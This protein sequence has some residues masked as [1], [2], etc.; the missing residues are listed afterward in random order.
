MP[1]VDSKCFFKKLCFFLKFSE[2]L[3][4]SIDPFCFSIDRKL[5][6]NV[7]ESLC[8]FRSIEAVFRSIETRETCFLKGQNVFFKRCFFKKKFNLSSLSDLAKA[9]PKIFCRFPPE[10]LQGFCL[11]RPVSPFCPS[12]CVLFHDFMHF[13]CF[14]LGIFGTFHILGLLMIETFFLV[15]LIV[16]FLF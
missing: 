13:S 15:K 10:F 8:L 9:P 3:P 6:K 5:F 7:R 11:P 12:F 4:I 2:P 14:A 1:W 16:G